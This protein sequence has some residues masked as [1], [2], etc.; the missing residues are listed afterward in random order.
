MKEKGDYLGRGREPAG[1]Q[2]GG[3]C[4]MIKVHY[5]HVRK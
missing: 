1:G 3:G 2:G 5:I 4:D